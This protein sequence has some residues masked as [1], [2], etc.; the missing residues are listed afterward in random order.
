MTKIKSLILTICALFVVSSIAEAAQQT[1]KKRRR[2]VQTHKVQQNTAAR[3]AYRK[4]DSLMNVP[5][6]KPEI[7]WDEKDIPLEYVIT[8]DS[9]LNDYLS[10][11][12]KRIFY[13]C[14][15]DTVKQEPLSDEE[16]IKRLQSI[17]SIVEL[18]Y[19]SV[20]RDFISLYTIKRRKL[21]SSIL[22]QSDF[23]FPIF[24]DA[25]EKEGVPLELKYLPV[26][27]SA[28]NAKAYSPAGASGLWQFISSTGRTYG[29]KVNS[30]L[31]ERRDPIKS[32]YAAARYLKHLYN[33]YN[34][35]TLVIAAYNCGPG[36]VNKAIGKTGG[37]KDYWA[38]YPYLPR[39]T[40]GYVPA[41]IAATYAM[42][43]YKEHNICPAQV[44]RP[45]NVDTVHVNE[46]VHLRQIAEVLDIDLDDLRTLNP[47][48]RHDIV[49]GN[50]GECNLA[51]P[52]KKISQYEMYKNTIL[53]HNIDN[54]VKHRPQV[55]PAK[56]QNT[57]NGANKKQVKEPEAADSTQL[58]KA[59]SSLKTTELATNEK[60][61]AA[62]EKTLDKNAK[63]EVI[64]ENAGNTPSSDKKASSANANKTNGN[65]SSASKKNISK[66]SSI[67]QKE[68][69][70][71]E[72]T[73]TVKAGDTLYS[74]AL[75]NK[76]SVMSI[77]EWNSLNNDNLRI[78][79]TI[80]VKR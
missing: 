63:T 42:H 26:I 25:L 4:Q 51:L 30:L 67:K 13:P 69:E 18:T 53:A 58:A 33:I 31:D 74:I 29:L 56:L 22:G 5:K 36:N 55:E 64:A 24:E 2:T 59:D 54:Y 52:T 8:L 44:F 45:A 50:A 80:I 47:Q 28:L 79:Q 62:N 76:V 12:N 65:A 20:V 57:K 68:D 34:D 48:Y 66:N 43:Y 15:E 21:T 1:R 7:K 32:S 39:E 19:N 27:E 78:G 73:Y 72:I 14:G 11:A 46:K 6:V 60:V 77:K 10:L 3:Q 61:S 17:P 41:F 75:R 40:R 23:Y 49:P 70:R 16:Y 9:T 37:V 38:I 71:K 35:W